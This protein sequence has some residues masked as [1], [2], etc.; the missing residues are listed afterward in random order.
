TR[1]SRDWSSD[2]CSSDLLHQTQLGVH[3]A[4][5]QA[6]LLQALAVA[7]VDLEAVAMA[8]VDVDLAVEAV[9]QRSLAQHA[10]IAPQ[11]HGAALVHRSEERRVGKG[12]TPRGT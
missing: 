4:D 10:V 2:V 5:A 3:P 12:S 11:P 1:F 7:V 6:S 9:G 8:L